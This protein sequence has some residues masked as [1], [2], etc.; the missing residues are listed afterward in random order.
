MRNAFEIYQHPREMRTTI[1]WLDP[2]K[3]RRAALA[4]LLGLP[5][6]WLVIALSTLGFI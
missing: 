6:L 1:Y 3:A 2:Q 4:A 5:V